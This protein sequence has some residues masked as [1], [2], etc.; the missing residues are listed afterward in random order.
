MTSPAPVSPA[1]PGSVR[2]GLRRDKR[3]AVG[4]DKYAY[5][6]AAEDTPVHASFP[7][8]REGT[9]NG[10]ENN[11]SERCPDGYVHRNVRRYTLPV[12]REDQHRHDDCASAYPEK[13]CENAG[14]GA[15]HTV[16]KQCCEHKTGTF[17]SRL[18]AWR[19][20]QLS[21]I[22][23]IPPAALPASV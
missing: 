1:K 9:G 4:P 3:A 18:L 8:M 11:A 6:D 19:M 23:S 17:K 20:I 13:T 22:P 2:D 10:R 14:D 5:R 16:K 12:E 7:V 21:E 15:H